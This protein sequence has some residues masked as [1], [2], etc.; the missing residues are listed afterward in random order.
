MR[1]ENQ[2]DVVVPGV[3]GGYEIVRIGHAYENEHFIDLAGR[4]SVWELPG[5]SASVYPILRKLEPPT[6]I[7]RKVEIH[8]W[9]VSDD[10]GCDRIVFG[11]KQY[12]ED[13][14]FI[15]VKDLGLSEVLEVEI[16]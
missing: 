8:K 11:T 13:C 12:I 9:L 10:A 7:T 16:S 1:N 4:V 2:K 3:P 14:C 6:P 5:R 15:N